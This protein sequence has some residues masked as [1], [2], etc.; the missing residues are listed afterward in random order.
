S[1]KGRYFFGCSKWPKCDFVAW[2]LPGSPEDIKQKE[3]AAAKAAAA[4]NSGEKEKAPE[5]AFNTPM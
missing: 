4:E 2:A 5:E 3:R 1:K